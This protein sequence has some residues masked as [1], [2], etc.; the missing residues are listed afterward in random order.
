MAD[1]GIKKISQRKQGRSTATRQELI[2]AARRIFARDGFEAARLQD[3]A[4]AM[5]KTRG[6]FYSHFQDKEDVFFAIFEEDILRDQIAYIGRLRMASTLEERVAILVKQLE[7]IMRDKAR[8]LL[9][10]EFKMYAIRHP[11]KRKRLAEL[12]VLMCTH[13]AAAVKLDLLPE[14]HSDD[15]DEQRSRTAQFGSFL[16][17]L[18]LNH[19]F[20]PVGLDEERLRQQI[21]CGVRSLM[22]PWSAWRK[23]NDSLCGNAAPSEA[24]R[25]AE[26]P[27]PLTGF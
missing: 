21:E 6:A 18:V 16:D 3:I 27:P 17:G 9:Y 22:G 23:A 7:A 4:S 11:H 10:I 12:H 25:Q 8:V 19:Y 24:L 5:G 13:G 14:L 15:P 20:D 26:Q 2:D 1:S